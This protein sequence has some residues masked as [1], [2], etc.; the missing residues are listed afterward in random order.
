MALHV[1]AP[2]GVNLNSSPPYTANGAASIP[3]CVDDDIGAPNDDTDYL[4]INTSTGDEELRLTLG[5][6]VDTERVNTFTLRIRSRLTDYTPFVRVGGVNYAGTARSTASTYVTFDEVWDENPATN[7]PWTKDDLDALIVGVITLA[8]P[9]NVG[10]YTQILGIVD[11]V[12][13]PE[14]IGQ[15]RDSSS[16]GLRLF[17][18][19]VVTVQV[20]APLRYADLELGDHLA[21]SHQAWPMPGDE[22]AGI[23]RWQRASL[24]VIGIDE[25][26]DTHTVLLRCVDLRGY[27]VSKWDTGISHEPPSAIAQ[28]MARLTTGAARTFARASE[29]YTEN[30]AA[31]E[32]GGKQVVLVGEDVEKYHTDGTLIEGE[33]T[34]LQLRSSFVSGLTGWTSAG[35]GSNG[36]A[37]A[38]DTSDL[39]FDDSITPSCILFTAG[40]PI[41]ASDLQITGTATASIA[42]GSTVCLSIDHKDG[43]AAAPLSYAI[44]RSSDSAWWRDSDQ[45]WQVAKT[46]NAMTGSTDHHRH[47][48]QPIDVGA[49]ATTLTVVVGVPNATGVAGQTNRLH[50]VQIEDGPYPTSRIVTDAAAA[51]READELEDE[52]NHGAR[53]FTHQHG[54]GFRRVVT[55]WSSSDLP[56]GARRVLWCA[57]RGPGNLDEV[58]YE[59]ASGAWVYERQ[60][61]AVSYQ[62]AKTATVTSGEEYDIAWRWTG[63]DE[64][65]DVAAYTL[66]IFVDGA[67][68]TDAVAVA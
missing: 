29:A 66:S 67:K 11:H 39:L 65:L 24:V 3:E 13:V 62:A 45:T 44:Q 46:W 9:T 5:P 33:R 8:D 28:G 16:R 21:L 57:W 14:L 55:D 48:T 53:T 15:V 1:M 23:K 52:N 41:H 35:T 56:A 17:R 18:R 61:A 10:R 63:E 49:S 40:S 42:A 34:N 2:D 38:T 32:A 64:E 26:L 12:G 27:L 43:S 54:L 25:N 37:I 36:S 47:A 30:A 31:A 22:G 59:Q 6:M 4:S 19:P 68:G 60:R 51:A 50:H 58:R 7:E 20:R